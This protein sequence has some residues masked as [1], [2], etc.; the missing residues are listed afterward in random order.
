MKFYSLAKYINREVFLD[1]QLQSAGANQSRLLEKYEKKHKTIKHQTIAIKLVYAFLFGFITIIPIFAYLE[2]IVTPDNAQI[3][4]ETLILGSSVLFGI[5]FVMLLLYTMLLGLISTSSFM[6]GKVF[7]WLRTLPLSKK[8]I[9][10]LGFTTIFRSFDL[11]M[12][13][14]VI[15]FPIV[16]FIITQNPLF[17]LICI[18]SSFLNMIFSF[19][20]LIILGERVSRVFNNMDVKSKKARI[21]QIIT[22]AGYFLLAFGTGFV[23]QF[24]LSTI[25]DLLN[26]FANYEHILLLNLILSLIPYPFGSGYLLSASLFLGKVHPELIIT[27]F[28]GFGLFILLTWGVYKV[29]LRNLRSMIAGDLNGRKAQTTTVIPVE[30]IQVEIKTISPIKSYIRKDLTLASRDFQTLMFFVM[31]IIMPIVMILSMNVPIQR[32]VSSIESMMIMWSIVLVF[33]MFIPS[34]LVVGFLNLEESGAT[35]IASL[36]IV[37]RDQAKAKLI[38]MSIIQSISFIIMAILLTVITANMQVLALFLVSLPIAWSFLFL[39]FEMKIRLFG[40]MKYK[41]TIDELYKGHK[42][43][44]WILMFVVEFGLYFST[45]IISFA[46]L[47]VV[48]IVGMMIILLAFSILGFLSLIFIF[49]KMFPKVKNMHG[50]ETGGALRE[51][52]LLG[53]LVLTLFYMGFMFLPAFLEIFLFMTFPSI[54]NL[55]F[56]VLLFIEFFLI[57]GFLGL[58]WLVIVPHGLKLPKKTISFKEYLEVIH[59]STVKPLKRNVSIGIGSFLIFA[60]IVFIGA[61]ILGEYIFEPNILFGSPDPTVPGIFGLG[62]FLFIYMLI[63]GIWEEIA[64]RGVMIPMLSKKYSQKKTIIVSSVVF[65]LVHGFNIITLLLIGANPIGVLFQVIYAAF[66][67]ISFAYMYL[68]TE[69]LLP[70]IILHYLI[71]SVGLILLYV[72]I[73]DIIL[74]GIFLIGFIGILPVAPIILLVRAIMQKENR[75]KIGN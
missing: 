68:K 53:I 44:K 39:M 27:S 9:K 38:L 12:I 45:I 31:P 22:M 25:Q 75:K 54:L 7:E 21:A 65:G 13:M 61:N 1:S 28:I 57:F 49:T 14:A 60:I 6:S 70:G 5:Y 71:D 46:L 36:P 34:M 23:V 48:G 29:A 69:S 15:T 47:G 37:P 51:N 63:P 16:M 10:K 33:C 8:D 2:I 74:A 26:V 41:Y 18:V 43:K 55:S 11:P 52:P 56:I 35:T 67:G 17:F 42:I 3:S 66:L 62:W 72:Y 24:A 50:Y 58:L 59:F 30:E 4:T 20:V 40:K 73:E 19:S 32:D 64:F